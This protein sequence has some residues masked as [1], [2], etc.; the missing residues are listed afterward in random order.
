MQDQQPRKHPSISQL[1]SLRM[2]ELRER[3][4]NTAKESARL[5][6]IIGTSGN[7]SARDSQTGL[8]AITPS[9]IPYDTLCPEDLP[10][11]DI[12][13]QVVEAKEGRKPSSETP[14]HTEVYR[15]RNDVHGVVHTHSTFATVFSVMGEGIPTVTIPLAVYGPVPVSPFLMPGSRELAIRATQ[16]LGPRGKAVLLQNHGVLCVGATVEEAL[17]CAGYVE[18]G[19]KIA[20]LARV[21]GRCTKIPQDAAH[22]IR[23]KAQ[24]GKS[25]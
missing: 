9:G 12:R 13:G 17:T 21:A 11:I 20:Y 14:L 4:L 25:V 22:S 18:E 24:E 1:E 8:V 2:Q 19:A 5:G 16:S 7:V 3:V 23:D 6:L 15:T 10:I